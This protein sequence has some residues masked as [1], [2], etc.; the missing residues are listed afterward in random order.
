[1]NIQCQKCRTIEGRDP[2]F[3]SQMILIRNFIIPEIKNDRVQNFPYLILS[4]N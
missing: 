3:Q 2:F 1:M 4:A